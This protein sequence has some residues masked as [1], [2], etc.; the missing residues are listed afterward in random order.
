MKLSCLY[1]L[2]STSKQISSSPTGQLRV[3]H[4]KIALVAVS[5]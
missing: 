5:Q 2:V 1:I 3:I 4:M